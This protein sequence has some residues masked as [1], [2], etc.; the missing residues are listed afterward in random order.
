[1]EQLLKYDVFLSYSSKDQKVAEGVCG[2]LESKGY[3]CFV[4][5][6]DIPKGEVW[7]S[8]IT[9]AIDASKMMVV[10]F[11]E[12]F[13]ASEQTDREIE[14]AAENKIPILTFRITNSDFTGAKKYYLKNLNWIDAFPNPD[15][16][17]RELCANVSKLLNQRNKE[18]LVE[19]RIKPYVDKKEDTSGVAIH[20]ETDVDCKLF[21]YE[22]FKKD[23][24]AG[25]NNIVYLRPGKYKLIF[26][27]SIYSDIKKQALYTVER[28]IAHDYIEVKLK[29]E[30]GKR[31][32]L[33]EAIPE[34]RKRAEEELNEFIKKGDEY[35]SSDNYEK[36]LPY[37]SQ[38]AERGNAHAQSCLGWMFQY[39]KGVIQDYI[40]AARWYKKA[41]EQGDTDAKKKI[42]EIERTKTEDAR[43]KMEQEAG[44]CSHD[45]VD[46]IETVD[47]I[48]I[49][50]QALAHYNAKEY[51]KALPL[52]E[53]IAD[54]NAD[55][56][57]YLGCMYFNGNGISQDYKKA[58]CYFFKASKQGSISAPYNL[59][60]LF[61]YGYGVEKSRQKAFEWYQQAKSLGS[62]H[63]EKKLM[64][65][66]KLKEVIGEKY[67]SKNGK[68][69][70]RSSF[71][72][73]SG[74]VVISCK[75]GSGLQFSEGLAS[76]IDEN[77]LFGYMDL[78]GKIV[79]P[80]QWE[81]AG[82]FSEGLAG[83]KEIN[84]KSGFIN[85][86]GQIV[87]PCI[88]D[89]VWEFKNGYAMIL[90]QGKWGLLK[91]DG[92]YEITTN[93]KWY[94][95]RRPFDGL[96]ATQNQRGLWGYTRNGQLVIPCQWEEIATDKKYPSLKRSVGDFHDGLAY[97]PNKEGKWGFINTKGEL[98]I[99]YKWSE[100]WEFS[101]G[102]GRVK[103]K[104]GKWGFID[105]AGNYVIPCQ[106]GF[107]GAF[108]EGYAWVINSNTYKFVDKMGN[109]AFQGKSWCG[110]ENFQ[111][112]TAWV[113]DGGIWRL[114][115]KTGTYL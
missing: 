4:A 38:A 75:Y 13:N 21:V 17:F 92:T 42:E 53:H 58:Y 29:E 99:P 26:E 7:A 14:L 98:V 50:Q 108:S 23:L 18:E 115:D 55:A 64:Y 61:E 71:V 20:I 27:S 84:G 89:E 97:V 47:D 106:W 78:D 40:E 81:F 3:R 73:K 46:D 114:I 6:R 94:K 22:E 37:Y 107:V 65:I 41:A 11:S 109:V 5:Y 76:I 100:A 39:G 32:R 66:G 45:L 110:V 16:F 31:K 35:F 87:I 86:K 34:A 59:G 104:D 83:I 24:Y 1:M 15:S 102:R 69:K 54:I 33:E 30:V 44:E 28:E 68:E 111:D 90:Y 82:D 91:K 57:N 93:E 43:R 72:D 56:S 105:K 10:V 9:N 48:G 49:Y 95:I 36:A 60:I 8:E 70:Y 25:K 80:C 77:G 63:A 103:N 51:E 88:Y 74:K 96:S 67:I 12:N 62:K 85:K 2:Y 101:E 113:C 19:E 112:G 52:F 79:I